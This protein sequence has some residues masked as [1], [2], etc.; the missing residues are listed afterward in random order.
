MTTTTAIKERPILFSGLMSLAIAEGRKTQTR[1]L[2]RPDRRC[3]Y[4][5]PGDRLWVREGWSLVSGGGYIAWS[6]EYDEPDFWEGPI[7]KEKPK[8]WRLAFLRN[9]IMGDL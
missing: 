2:V 8:G 3:P 9:W 7:P 5:G 6:G 4:G 1:R